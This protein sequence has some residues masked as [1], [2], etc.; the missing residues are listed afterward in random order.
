MIHNGV[1]TSRFA[2]DAVA[3]ARLR[4][5]L[6]IPVDAFVVGIAAAHRPEKRHDRF[7][8]LMERL[9]DTGHDVWGLAVGGGSLLEDTRREVSR[10]RARDRIVVAGARDDMVAAYSAMNLSVLLSDSTETFPLVS[11]EAQACAVPVL[12]V[13]VG[14][15]G[16]TMNRG[17]SGFI[18]PQDDLEALVDL[19]VGFIR[20]PQRLQRTGVEAR[21]FVAE[22]LS[23]SD[24]VASWESLLN[25][26][27]AR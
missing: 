22:N 3:G 7:I 20:D 27:V 10:S 15:V 9:A 23:E 26:V 5:E 18:V 2:R 16:E 14:G 8:R 11:L 13:E 25:E 17:S 4:S 21:D 1:D 12:A 19:I 6:G 24:M